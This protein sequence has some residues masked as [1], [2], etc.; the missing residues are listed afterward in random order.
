MFQWTYSKLHFL[1]AG[2]P[3]SIPYGQ[4][5]IYG[6]F[7][8]DN[9]QIGDVII[10]D[11]VSVLI[12]VSF[13]SDYAVLVLLMICNFLSL[14]NLRRLQERD[15]WHFLHFHLMAYLDSDSLM[16]QLEKSHQF[17]T[18]KNFINSFLSFVCFRCND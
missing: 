12:S 17:G 16:L 8:Q 9:V 2:T 10:K 7:S 4:G 1:Y 11:Q 3:C 14:R 18:H 15:H 6:F 5:S 13:H